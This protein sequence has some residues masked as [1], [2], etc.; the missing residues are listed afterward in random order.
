V[1][2]RDYSNARVLDRLLMYE[3]RIESSPYRT[4]GELRK[5]RLLRKM[6]PPKEG[7][8]PEGGVAGSEP[9]WGE[10]PFDKL[11][12]CPERQPNGAGSR[13][14]EEGVERGRPTY[15]GPPD[16]STTNMP[17]AETPH[18]SNIPSF[19]D[20]DHASGPLDAQTPACETNPR[21]DRRSLRKED[22]KE[23]ILS[24]NLL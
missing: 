17:P 9:A 7:A 5:Q 8:A 15:Q 13:S 16:G 12:T 6:D 19:Q 18:H 3:R 1:V 22:A 24:G 23:H 20:S 11:R 10:R 14:P 21:C 4:M 2:V